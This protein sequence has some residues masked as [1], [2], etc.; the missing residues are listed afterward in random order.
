MKIE[1]ESRNELNQSRRNESSQRELQLSKE[2][3]SLKQEVRHLKIVGES[4]S[5]HSQSP[6]HL[7]GGPN[8]LKQLYDRV[9]D[10]SPHGNR[11]PAEMHPLITHTTHNQYT[12]NYIPYTVPLQHPP[13][14]IQESRHHTHL[15]PGIQQRE[16]PTTFVQSIVTKSPV[17]LHHRSMTQLPYEPAR[18]RMVEAHKLP[19]KPVV[20][21]G[22][23]LGSPPFSGAVNRSRSPTTLNNC[24]LCGCSVCKEHE[25]MPNQQAP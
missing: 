17:F 18:T 2:I 23:R 13:S 20:D 9:D 7:T 12:S 14:L 16:V 15:S 6:R 1:R 11:V 8:I 10:R 24:P 5:H 25:K 4:S 19:A 22:P 3:E 21:Y